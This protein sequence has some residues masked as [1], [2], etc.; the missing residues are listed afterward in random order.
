M[1]RLRAQELLLTVPEPAHDERAYVG[2]KQLQERARS[3]Q[4]EVS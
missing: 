3:T 1:K 2:R 4:Q